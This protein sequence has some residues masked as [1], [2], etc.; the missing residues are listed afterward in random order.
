RITG[1]DGI[2]PG[3]HYVRILASPAATDAEHAE[4]VRRAAAGRAADSE[5]LEGRRGHGGPEGAP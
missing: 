1:S 2:F 5:S 4:G 3:S